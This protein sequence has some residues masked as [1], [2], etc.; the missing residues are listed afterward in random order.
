MAAEVAL[1]GLGNMGIAVAERLLDAG[2]TLAVY[3]RTPGRDEELVARGATRLESAGDALQ[4]ADLCLTLLSDDAAVEAVAAAVLE[5]A[6]RGTTLVEM[7]TISVAASARVADAAAAHDVA[8]LRA[9]FSGNPGAV[10]AGK[11]AIFVSG[12]ADAAERCTPLLE[13]IAPTVRY[14]GE[15]ERARALKLAL[16]IL[17]GGTAELLAEAVVLGES[18]GLDRAT[19]LDVV[20]ASV[21]GSP[22]VAYKSDALRNDDYSAT[23]TTAMMRKDV[24]LIL[25]LARQAG[26]ELPITAE[27]RD[28][29]EAACEHGHADDDFISVILELQERSGA[30]IPVKDR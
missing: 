28:V 16:Q 19:L 18:A 20:G 21:V 6:R 23:F 10:R 11:A 25:D 4:A 2:H 29:L 12:P 13:S 5:G 30:R 27:V 1:V 9:P 3:N 7:S 17:I 15:D 26:V 22:F 14:V 24:D 8:Y